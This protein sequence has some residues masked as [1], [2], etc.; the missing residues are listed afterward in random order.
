MRWAVR[1]IKQA[2][3]AFK[4]LYGQLRDDGDKYFNYFTTL[5]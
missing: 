1:P 5:I 3:G 4:S 2:I